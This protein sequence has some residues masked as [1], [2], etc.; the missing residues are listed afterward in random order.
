MGFYD[1][2]QHNH[3]YIVFTHKMPDADALCSAVAT[4]LWIESLDSKNTVDI[5]LDIEEEMP[6]LY[7][8]ILVCEYNKPRL[9]TY[10]CAITVDCA[11]T[12]RI[13]L[14]GYEL[15]NFKHII[16]IDHH[17]T[18][19]WFG[20]ANIV[21]SKFA[22]TGE[23]L[24]LLMKRFNYALNDTLAKLIYTSILTDTNCFTK[25]SVNAHTF[26]S[27]AELLKFNFNDKA[28]KINFF[29]NNSKAKIYLSQKAMGS[30][31]FYNNDTIAIM[32]IT[33]KNFTQ[34]SATYEDSFGIVDNGLAI[35]GVK[36]C[37]LFIEKQP[38]E[39]YV[40][41]RGKGTVDIVA[42]AENFGG[43]GSDGQAAFQFKNNIS[44]IEQ[45]FIQKATE[46]I[47]NLPD[48][49]ADKVIDF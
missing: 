21:M 34:T 37:A 31:K 1:I 46:I 33:Q 5:I 36:I 6:E 7:K 17:I 43:G 15:K 12:E 18:N 42:L 24:Y 20:T 38:N 39:Y 8:N 19:T 26:S 47:A 9:T 32:K 4:K 14:G 44:D 11:S 41:L 23:V 30:L 35:E 40:S 3:S 29:K 45:Q 27:I 13:A 25:I 2:I 22:S 49:E 16:N 10:D 28:I 48:E